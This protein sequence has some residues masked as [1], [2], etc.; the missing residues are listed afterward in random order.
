MI[1]GR[2]TRNETLFFRVTPT[3]KAV[4]NYVKNAI[5]CKSMSEMLRDSSLLV[6]DGLITDAVERYGVKE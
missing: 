2:E 3:E 6:A 4:L 5:G 1:N